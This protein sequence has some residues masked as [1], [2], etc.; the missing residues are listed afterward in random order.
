MPAQANNLEPRA[1][2]Q[3]KPAHVAT[4]QR[5]PEHVAPVEK[6]SDPRAV[7]QV[8]GEGTKDKKHET[9][10]HKKQPELEDRKS[11]EAPRGD[12]IKA[13]KSEVQENEVKAPTA[14]KK[15]NLAADG[16]KQEE[17][18]AASKSKE[19]RRGP[20]LEEEPAPDKVARPSV[21][22]KKPTIAG[23]R[24]QQ[25]DTTPG[26]MFA[27]PDSLK[28][29]GEQ[30]RD[31]IDKIPLYM[32]KPGGVDD[33]AEEAKPPRL[34]E[35]SSPTRRHELVK[36]DDHGK[37]HDGKDVDHRKDHHGRKEDEH[38]RHHREKKE[39]EYASE[40]HAKHKND[41][42]TKRDGEH[43]HEHRAKSE[44][45]HPR[46]AEKA[47]AATH[48]APPKHQVHKKRHLDENDTFRYM[49]SSEEAKRAKLAESLPKADR[50]EQLDDTTHSSLAGKRDT[51]HRSR[52]SLLKDSG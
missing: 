23:E 14:E 24:G 4:G 45:D 50:L 33:K 32:R 35:K 11:G 36:K 19:H 12:R 44:A 42:H 28:K 18:A 6:K 3:R 40:H 43:E 46:H 49:K 26:Q 17:R 8:P 27:M 2:E 21:H 38:A 41:P 1:T 29:A 13:W 52:V 5:G 34:V 10:K 20:R 37:H 47:V 31:H 39:A 16:P 9:A 7:R 22:E 48:E 15:S 51:A 30:L 25:Q